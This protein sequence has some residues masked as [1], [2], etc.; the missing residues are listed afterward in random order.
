MSAAVSMCIQFRSYLR[1]AKFTLCT[2][3]KSL[4]W[5]HRFNDTEGMIARWLHTLQ[6]FQFSIVQRAGR[7]HGNADGL[8]RVPTSPCGQCARVDCPPVDTAIEVVDQPFDAEC[9]GD[10]EDA[11]LVPLQFGE[12]WVAQ[13]DDDL[14]RPASQS[15]ENFRITALQLQ[16]ST[17]ITLLTLIRSDV[18]PPWSEVKSLCSEL[19]L[20]WHHRN[21]ILADANGV[22][23]RKRSSP[24]SELHLLVPKPA[25]VQL[26]LAYHV[27]LFGGNL[28][29][30]WT[31]A[32]LSHRFYW[33]GMSDDVKDW[34]GQCTVCMKMKS[35]TGRHHLPAIAGIE[36]PWIFLMFATPHR[37]AIVTY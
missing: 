37:M 4:V 2:D 26:F 11:D 5:L 8:S 32:R 29:R 21:N 14:S 18:F 24:G 19:H 15:G 25:L 10:S 33:S 13:L 12:D 34:L 22:I 9:V 27:S 17:C 3:H 36:L 6:Q 31:L 1:G 23:W 35:P 28:G 7:D 20:L 30:N 16:D